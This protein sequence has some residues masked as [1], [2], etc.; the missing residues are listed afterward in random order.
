MRILGAIVTLIVA[1]CVGIR[2]GWD[3]FVEQL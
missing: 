3:A 1:V 2:A